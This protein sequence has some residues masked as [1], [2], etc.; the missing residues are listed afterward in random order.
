MQKEHLPIYQIQ[1]FEALSQKER[2]F[3]F[4][5]FATHLQEH[6]FIRE[7]HKH[8]F[9][10]I[11][12]VTKGTGVHTIDF[13]EYE[14]KPGTVFFMTPGQVH[15]WDLSADAD[16]YVI[17]FTHGFYSRQY[18]DRVLYDYPFFNALLSTPVLSLSDVDEEV[19]RPVLLR[20]EHEYEGDKP[21]RGVMLSRY[22]DIL[23]IELT[24]LFQPSESIAGS[25]GRDQ[26]LLQNLE[27]LIDLHYKA[28]QP[29][30]FYAE[31]LHVTPKHLNE[32]CKKKLG[33]TTKELIQ[34]R[35][36]LEAQRLLVHA[37]LTSSQ[38]ASKLGYL[39]NAYFFRF[40][41]K[42]LGCTPEQ[43]RAMNQ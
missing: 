25:T 28:H 23:M 36:L 6:Q 13:R 9:Y 14:V 12:M 34:H 24:R 17:F 30:A 41:K 22:L 43:F 16:G 29:V 11:M 31:H 40:F 20:L 7:P 27:R 19:L 39:D 38:I 15:S 42:Q 10:I 32:V 35:L 18:P 5:S 1:D 8:D 21:M 26:T 3:Y 2:Y 4:S 37:D 33:K